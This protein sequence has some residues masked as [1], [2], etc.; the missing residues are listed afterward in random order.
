VRNEYDSK[1]IYIKEISE[2]LSNTEK[3]LSSTLDKCSKQ[4][5]Q[6]IELEKQ[7]SHMKTEHNN[8][9]QQYVFDLSQRNLKINEMSHE[10][11]ALKEHSKQDNNFS[12]LSFT[13]CVNNQQKGFGKL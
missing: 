9:V 11:E 5:S 3:L 6:I 13:E 7:I 2:S 4:Q 8:I 1:T 10:I 12:R